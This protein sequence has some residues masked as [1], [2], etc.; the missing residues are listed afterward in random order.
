MKVL[1][2]MPQIQHS[3][4]DVFLFRP[5]SSVISQ[6]NQDG[7]P[8]GQG[9]L[10]TANE[11]VQQ[12]FIKEVINHFIMEEKSLFL[13]Y[14]CYFKKFSHKVIQSLFERHFEIL[15][16]FLPSSALIY[17][18]L[19]ICLDRSMAEWHKVN[20]N[21]RTFSN[22]FPQT[23]NLFKCFQ[24]LQLT[25]KKTIHLTLCTSMCSCTSLFLQ[26]IEEIP[27]ILKW[28]ENSSYKKRL[29]RVLYFFCKHLQSERVINL[30]TNE[31]TEEVEFICRH[32]QNRYF[33]WIRGL[34]TA[35]VSDPFSI[36]VVHYHYNKKFCSIL[37]FKPGKISDASSSRL[38][39]EITINAKS[40]E[41]LLL[42]FSINGYQALIRIQSIGVLLFSSNSA[43]NQKLQNIS[44]GRI[45][46]QKI[47]K[48]V[49]LFSGINYYHQKAKLSLSSSAVSKEQ[50]IFF[51]ELTRPLAISKASCLLY[52]KQ[53]LPTVTMHI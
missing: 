19:N 53:A 41:Y 46:A 45:I 28:L 3:P 36:I 18:F 48:A 51:L 8:F 47:L 20:T 14:K 16:R 34:I 52:S 50:I 9:L 32:W 11:L 39:M 10:V 24:K 44:L 21:Q 2:K 13:T 43:L 27:C 35:S 23:E 42:G 4:D 25:G 1:A 30:I 40:Y 37:Q 22:F 49:G 5:E 6:R 29:F 12:S 15:P 38:Q 17:V 7:Y 26:F 31:I 33:I